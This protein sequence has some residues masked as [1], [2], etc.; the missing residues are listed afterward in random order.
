MEYSSLTN[1]QQLQELRIVEA[2]HFGDKE[3]L[4]LPK[5]PNL[6]RLTLAETS[7]SD[8]WLQVARASKTLTNVTV[9]ARDRNELLV[10]SRMEPAP[11]VA[12]SRPNAHRK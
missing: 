3:A 11:R 12:S 10:W 8:S 1:M 5:I 7:V 2:P 6:K 9:R 4:Y